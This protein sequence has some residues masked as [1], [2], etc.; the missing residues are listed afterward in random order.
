M[1]NDSLQQAQAALSE[2]IEAARTGA[3]IPI[4]LTGQLEALGDLLAKASEEAEKAAQ[5]AASAQPPELAEYIKEQGE[6]V[7]V[8]VHDLRSPLTAVRGYADM[9]NTPAMG[10]LTDMQKQFLVVIRSNVKRMEGLLT[11]VSDVNKL[12]SNRLRL[13][14]KMDMA[15][16][17]LGMVEKQMRPLADELGRTLTFDIPQGLPILN[18]DGEILVRVLVKLVENALRYSPQEDAEVVISAAADDSNLIITVR[19]NGIGMMPEELEQLQKRELYWR[20]ENEDVRAFKG[21]GLG[22]PIAYGLIE[23]LEGSIA[24]ES[25]AGA[26]T[27]FTLRLPG[28]S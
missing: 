3:I 20:S 15:K 23:H 25:E 16:N 5:K 1:A 10:E 11:D 9:L 28:M 19:D 22:I 13:A 21:S 14:P 6:F 26:G 8:A 2:L 18:L 24:V 4:R 7:S 17:V 12:R 27:M